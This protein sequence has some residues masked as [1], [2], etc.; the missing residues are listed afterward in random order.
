MYAVDSK[1]I[2]VE[3]SYEESDR[4]LEDRGSTQ[5]LKSKSIVEPTPIDDEVVL[6]QTNESVMFSQE[7]IIKE[8]ENDQDQYIVPEDQG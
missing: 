4:P 7:E 8:V 3:S 1:E 6:M 2:L 5:G